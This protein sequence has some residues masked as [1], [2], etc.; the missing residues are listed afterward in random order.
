MAAA[1]FL[2][3]ELIPEVA[4][5]YSLSKDP[6]DRGLSGVSTGGV[7]AFMAAW[8]R[9]DQFRRVLSFI[10]TFVS[11]KGADTLPALIRQDGTEAHPH[12]PAGRAERPHRRGSALRSLLRRQLAGQQPGD[13]RRVRI[14]RL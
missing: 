14:L 11:M 5:K 10:G 12:L 7:G 4:K 9:P 1:R 2:I 6:N 8:E 3:E 13:G